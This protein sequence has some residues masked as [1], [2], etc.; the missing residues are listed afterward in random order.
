MSN[1]QTA[2]IPVIGKPAARSSERG[3]LFVAGVP[4][5]G[6]HALA[7]LIS[8]HSCYQMIPRELAF[9]TAIDEGGLPDLLTGRITLPEFI[10]RMTNYWWKRAAPWDN[11]VTRGL[12]KTIPKDRLLRCLK[13]LQDTYPSGA[14]PAVR[15]FMHEMLD[16]IAD[17]AGKPA[18]IEMDPAN[19]VVAPLLYEIF[20]DMKLIHIIRD[21]RDVAQSI[22][23]L[24]WGCEGTILSGIVLWQRMLRE[25]H[26]QL[27]K[28]PSD[29]VLTVQLEHLVYSRREDTYSRILDFLELPDEPAM[30]AFFDEKISA[31]SAH[32]GRWRSSLSLPRQLLT[33]LTYRCSLIRLA[34]AGVSPRPT[35]GPRHGGWTAMGV[36]NRPQDD[37]IDPWADGR[38]RDA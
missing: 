36:I 11:A 32:I 13:C 38:A 5:S 21:G 26:Q 23:N 2:H 18:W 30:H 16:P 17:E 3:P 37:I 8:R 6:T 25:G 33:I 20:P 12:Y 4:R 22:T 1:K 27:Q 31:E 7:H 34:M 9:H 19:L 15:L 28:L 14:L 35:L 10:D 29:H 24:P